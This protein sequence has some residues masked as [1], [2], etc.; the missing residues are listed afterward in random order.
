MRNSLPGTPF[1][2]R[3]QARQPTPWKSWGRSRG[4]TSVCQTEVPYRRTTVTSDGGRTRGSASEGHTRIGNVT[5]TAGTGQGRD[6]GVVRG[7][8]LQPGTLAT[9]SLTARALGDCSNRGVDPHSAVPWRAARPGRWRAQA[10]GANKNVRAPTTPWGGFGRIQE[11]QVGPAPPG[12]QA[13]DRAGWSGSAGAPGLEF[14]FCPGTRQSGRISSHAK[15][16]LQ[17]GRPDG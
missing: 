6:G 13:H 16:R 5:E 12:C 10:P 9:G 14:G 17:T 8:V 11:A 1:S 4:L 7:L 2:E 3:D 15:K